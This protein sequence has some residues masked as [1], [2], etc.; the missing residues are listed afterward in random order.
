[1]YVDNINV[2]S[3]Q[4]N[5]VN[6]VQ[7]NF[8]LEVYP[9]PNKGKFFLEGNSNHAG[10]LKISIQNSL[11]EEVSSFTVSGSTPLQQF[12]D[13]GT[14]PSGVYWL[15]VQSGDNSIVKKVVKF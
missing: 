14:L 7:N 3:A 6:D 1:L 9:N 2:A 15:K 10:D 11:G 12:I 8:L 5:E 4:F 13:I